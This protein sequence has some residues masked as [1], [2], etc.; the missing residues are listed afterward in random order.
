MAYGDDAGRFTW[1]IMPAPPGIVPAVPGSPVARTEPEPEESRG[2]LVNT[3][4]ATPGYVLFAPLLSGTTYL[5]DG[6]GMVVHTWEGTHAPGASVY[7]LDNGHLLRTAR[8]WEV[9]VFKGG[10]QGSRIQEFTWDGKLVWDFALADEQRLLHHDIEPLPD[11]HVLAIAWEQKSAEA[12]RR[13]GRRPDL[14]PQKGLWP[15]V[16][17]ELDPLPPDDARIV[18]SWHMWD[19]LIQAHDPNAAN[20][21]DPAMVPHRIDING[22]GEPEQVDDTEIERLKTL[23]YVPLDATREE[24]RSDL[25]HTNA[26]AYHAGLDQI[27]L[28]VP[29][30]NEIW[31]VDH[32]GGRGGDL[33]Y[34]WGNPQAYGRGDESA[35]QLFAQHDVRWISEDLPG[36]GNLM[37]FNNNMGEKDAAYSA[38]F[39]IVPPLDSDG[40]YALPDDG[41]F[42]PPRPRWTY[43]AP[44]SFHASFISGAHRLPNGHT[45]ITAGPQGRFFEVT[46][47]GKIVWE[48]RSIYSGNLR[49][50]DGSP[51]HPV[52]K[53]TYPIFR[54]TKLA[55]EHP[56]LASRNLRPLDPQ[57][58][59]VLP[60]DKSAE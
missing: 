55:P 32:A 25:L 2:L 23:G 1:N 33:L 4:D 59:I 17:L 56:A 10:G 5:I 57:P 41:P 50:A 36:G 3:P 24:L 9:P 43:E 45:F 58:P 7:L 53:A 39:E 26:V 47:A 14:T 18:W 29:R 19:H 49:N 54:A 15:D 44:D 20:Y 13:A 37:I 28:S 22:D 34:R 48:Y 46:P 51:P 52:G 21:G 31:I 8:E 6:D 16:V 27:A 38:V 35:Q 12:S 40:R 30:F 42:G 11:G 60:T